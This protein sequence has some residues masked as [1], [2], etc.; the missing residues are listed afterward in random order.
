MNEPQ[1]QE[2][3]MEFLDEH[4]AKN[5][6]LYNCWEAN[7]CGEAMYAESPSH[8]VSQFPWIHSVEGYGYWGEIK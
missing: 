2:K 7:Q 6:C 8:L 1:M 4:G 3:F 5:A